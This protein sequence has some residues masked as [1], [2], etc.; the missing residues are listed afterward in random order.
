MDA[1]FLRYYER[2]L[3][4][5]RELGGEFAR[6]FPKIAGRLGLDSFECADPYVE[7][8]LEGFA[9]LS[10]RVQ[11]KIDAE[12]PAFTQHM[13]ELL[14]P[15]YLAPTPSMTVVQLRPS[16]REGSLASGFAVPRGTALRS[17]L[18]AGSSSCE[19]RTAH[20]VTLLPLEIVAA[21]YTSVVGQFVDLEKAQ[22]SGAKA[23][24]RIVLR[25]TGNIPINRLKLDALTFHI[26]GS[27]DVS[28]RLH[29]TLLSN[30][31]GLVAQPTAD[32]RAQIR[33][34]TRP[35]S[36][37]FYQVRR[38]SSFGSV[39]FGDDEALLPVGP[40]GF[41]GHRLLHE[42]FAFPARYMFA[43]LRGLAPVARAVEGEELELVLLFDRADARLEGA[44]RAQHLAL[45]CTPAVNLFPR[46]ADR[47]HV[48]ERAHE[49]HV[50][51]DRTRPLD[52]EVYAITQVLGYGAR[53]AN[54]KEF[55]PM[56]A[57]HAGARAEH[58]YYTLRREPRMLSSRERTRG[59]RSGYAGAEVFVSLVDGQFG[60]LD[61]DLRQIGV[62]TLCTNRDLPLHLVTGQGD[63]DFTTDSGAP[64]DSIRVVAGPSA[65]RNSPVYGD[66]A[67]RL[68]SHLSLDYM[69]LMRE[70]E[71]ESAKAVR[72]LLSLYADLSEPS[73]SKQ[74]EG[75]S[76]LRSQ[77]VVRPLP[78]PGPLTFG[79]GMEVT[80]ECDETAFEGGSAFV[81]GSVLER[82]FARY[83]S[84]NGFCETVLRS[85]QRGEIKRWPTTAGQRKVI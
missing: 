76:K 48:S 7:R 79:R 47:I 19:Y 51:P 63:T 8:L 58:H 43:E 22:F 59:P 75:L 2:E 66:L 72:S 33:A 78:F 27:N 20:D 85:L 10:A 44:V 3:K 62:S 23:A 57:L 12:F 60:P 13:L 41:Q 64:I 17:R 30:H 56:Y 15:G 46:V 74:L 26:V 35:A 29:E 68:L 42:Y 34:G 36:A 61:P 31:V 84:I 16:A 80:I 40:R 6:E 52:L 18:G 32:L 5:V 82:F 37:D 21:D 45:F 39:G 4:S 71:A 83:A 54:H 67:W 28:A 50:V 77:S 49:Y 65:P 11:L 25:T 14:Y 81:F 55:L 53:N 38:G 24:L 9:F 1:R 69:S 73:H 70:S